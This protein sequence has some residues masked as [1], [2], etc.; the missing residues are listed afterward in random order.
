[1]HNEHDPNI[2]AGSCHIRRDIK[3]RHSLRYFFYLLAKNGVVA[4][5]LILRS[6]TRQSH[7][8]Q[9]CHTTGLS[10][11]STIPYS[12][13]LILE[14]M[15]LERCRYLLVTYRYN[16]TIRKVSL[17]SREKLDTNLTAMRISHHRHQQGHIL[18]SKI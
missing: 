17:L 5:Q 10:I 12:Q 18:P 1:M 11:I 8:Q 4:S 15:K 7:V 2:D 16:A 3:C 13:L 14:A 9:C 6:T